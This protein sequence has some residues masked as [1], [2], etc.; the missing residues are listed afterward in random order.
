MVSREN[1]QEAAL[2]WEPITMLL[3]NTFEP[4]FRFIAAAAEFSGRQLP[5]EITDHE[6]IALL[7]RPL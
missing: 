1:D 2:N 5:G 7:P 4:A 6:R 3:P